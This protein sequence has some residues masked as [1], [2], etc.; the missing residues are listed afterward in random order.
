M[1]DMKGL[2]SGVFAPVVT[3]FRNDEILFAGLRDNVEKMNRT[4]L[5]GYFVLGTN[6]EYKSLSVPERMKVLDT[7]VRH[8]SPEKVIMAGCAAESTRETL[9]LVREAAYRGATMASLLMPSFFAKRIDSE[10]MVRFVTE[11]ADAS[12]VPVVLYNNPSVAAGVV[13]TPEVLRAV[14]G[15]P[16]VVGIKDS[17]SSTWRENL[18][19]ASDGFQVLAGSAS[20]FL[21]LLR[22]GGSGG[23]LSLANVFPHACAALYR[24]FIQG[25]GEEAE[26]LNSQI[27]E[28][29]RNVSGTYGVAGVKGA[30][31]LAGFVGGVPRRPLPGLTDA[32]RAD[33]KR[34]LE[35]K[36]YLS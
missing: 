14:A 8:G 11:V 28:L 30:M 5:R 1:S 36:G 27:V 35:E 32:Q 29:N 6:G 2:L 20:Y 25:R 12:P 31:D 7:V 9:E 24:A 22:G 13:I 16:N 15:H 18:K 4:G 17:S 34:V 33:L 23:V 19:S 3:P 10:V 21:E 26:K